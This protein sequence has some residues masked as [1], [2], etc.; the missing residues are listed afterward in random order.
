MI[1]SYKNKSDGN[2]EH[3]EC[4]GD[5]DEN[6]KNQWLNYSMELYKSKQNMEVYKTRWNDCQKDY[7]RC[8]EE[9]E[10]LQ[11]EKSDCIYCQHSK[12][13]CVRDKDA[14][15]QQLKEKKIKHEE[16]LNDKENIKEQMHRQ[17]S[18]YQIK[19]TKCES[20]LRHTINDLGRCEKKLEKTWF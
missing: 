8:K 9:K 15:I 7:E 5:N 6:L 20:N 11:D 18:E 17:C 19:L 14:C 12:D 4:E 2:K 3:M 13:T 1:S 16:C 10:K